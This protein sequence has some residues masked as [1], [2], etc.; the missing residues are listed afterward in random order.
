MLLPALGAG[1]L[2]RALGARRATT[3]GSE[4]RTQWS[5]ALDA[6]GG[7]RVGGVQ[8]DFAILSPRHQRAR[9]LHQPNWELLVPHRDTTMRAPV[10]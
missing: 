7:S 9:A 3:G 2:P 6:M 5:D 1:A 4:E 8:M 10:L